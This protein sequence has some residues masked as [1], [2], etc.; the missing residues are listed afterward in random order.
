MLA[1]S[2]QLRLRISFKDVLNIREI[3]LGDR[4]SKLR[5]ALAG[6]GAGEWPESGTRGDP[7]SGKKSGE[8]EIDQ[9]EARQKTPIES[10]SAF[11]EAPS[12]PQ[13]RSRA[14]ESAKKIAKNP[15]SEPKRPPRAPYI[16]VKWLRAGQKPA[17]RPAR[18]R[19]VG[20]LRLARGRAGWH[21]GF[22]HLETINMSPRPFHKGRPRDPQED[23]KGVQGTSKTLP[24]PS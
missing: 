15:P 2:A 4:R 8:W 12:E 22:F 20:N 18:G 11:R 19:H 16:N 5:G 13:S 23:P 24:R 17:A 3:K 9:E 1:S 21:V 6:P 10:P 14:S 7:E